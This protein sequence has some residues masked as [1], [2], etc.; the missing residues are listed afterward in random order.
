MTILEFLKL[1]G[2]LLALVGLVYG[3]MHKASRGTCNSHQNAFN[4]V[5]DRVDTLE[6][7][8]NERMAVIREEMAGFR[9]ALKALTEATNLMRQDIRE[10]MK[11][12]R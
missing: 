12:N 7:Q 5:H 8:H 2:P 6:K 10:L 9:E 4:R 3:I 1:W 11:D